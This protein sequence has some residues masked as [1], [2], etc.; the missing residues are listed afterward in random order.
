MV[1][2]ISVNVYKDKRCFR[3]K[4]VILYIKY[5][6]RADIFMF[7]NILFLLVGNIAA[8]DWLLCQA[9]VVSFL[10]PRTIGGGK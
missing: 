6:R 1:S 3:Q 5:S 8:A 2:V 9:G 4:Q 7:V 10:S